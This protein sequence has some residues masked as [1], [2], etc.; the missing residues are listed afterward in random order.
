MLRS[1]NFS[2][3]LSLS[4]PVFSF[5]SHFIGSYFIDRSPLLFAVILEYLRTGKWNQQDLDY[6]EQQK[7]NAEMEYYQIRKNFLS[8]LW[9]LVL[10]FMLSRCKRKEPTGCHW[11]CDDGGDLLFKLEILRLR[12]LSS[13]FFL[14]SL[15]IDCISPCLTQ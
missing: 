9:V 2:F 14:F 5:V 12:G 4:T 1:F 3:N 7:L 11:R 15:V 6:N 10:N 13:S 8:V